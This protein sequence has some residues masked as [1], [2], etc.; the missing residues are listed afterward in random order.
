MT[1]TKPSPLG[2]SLR[3]TSIECAAGGRGGS[4]C[5]MHS[6]MSA[7]KPVARLYERELQTKAGEARLRIPKLRQQTLEGRP[8][9][10]PTVLEKG[11][12]GQFSDPE[13][14]FAA[15]EDL[16]FREAVCPWDSP[17]DAQYATATRASGP[18]QGTVAGPL[19]G[20]VHHR[21]F[22]TVPTTTQ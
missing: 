18:I 10:I 2:M 14:A 8:M 11:T 15:A 12:S 13:A 16:K 5:A 6:A 9:T 3:L 20:F 17:R 1:E 19:H 4:G 21:D 7:A 22:S